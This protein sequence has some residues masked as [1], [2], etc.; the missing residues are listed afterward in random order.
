MYEMVDHTGDVAMRLQAPSFGELVAEGVRAI[1]SLLFS[2]APDPSS[3]RVRFEERVSG[4]DRE[5]L[6]VQAL[7]EALH[8]MDEGDRFPLEVRAREL[9]PT[10]L[11]L[12]LEGTPADGDRCRRS[13][14]VKAVTYHDLAVRETEE[15]LTTVVVLDV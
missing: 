7:S 10:E 2:G 14:E 15:G 1:A 6:L 4:I 11:E 13:E 9:G 12:S 5:D 3:P 8:W